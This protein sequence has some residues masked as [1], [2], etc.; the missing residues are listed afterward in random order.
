MSGDV[1]EIR[2]SPIREV[3]R[4]NANQR[5]HKGFASRML[6]NLA[7]EISQYIHLHEFRS[8]HANTRDYLEA[9]VHAHTVTLRRL[10]S[11]AHELHLDT[12]RCIAARLNIHS[13]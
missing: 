11:T 9:A 6:S 3:I 12:L 4:I 10:V 5:M 13:I 7:V 2:A 1:R 8:G